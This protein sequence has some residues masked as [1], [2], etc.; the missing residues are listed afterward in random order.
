MN[1]MVVAMWC[2]IKG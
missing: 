1:N 2:E